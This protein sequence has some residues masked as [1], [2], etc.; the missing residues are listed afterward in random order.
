MINESDAYALALAY[1]RTS[2]S[3]WGKKGYI[4]SATT[5]LTVPGCF[6]FGFGLPPDSTG[7]TPR[8]GGTWPFLV[9]IET[10]ACR[11]VAGISEYVKLVKL[12]RDS[13]EINSASSL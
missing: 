11:Q 5:T 9:D 12:S 10:G 4:L 1:A 13:R 3:G 7:R 2:I 6:V 8:L